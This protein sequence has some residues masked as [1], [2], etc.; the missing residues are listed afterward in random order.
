MLQVT[1]II[2]VIK[3]GLNIY[4]RHNISKGGAFP[5]QKGA[6]KELAIPNANAVVLDMASNEGT[7]VLSWRPNTKDKDGANNR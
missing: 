7:Q 5:P 1:H 3:V 6:A 2:K 4:S